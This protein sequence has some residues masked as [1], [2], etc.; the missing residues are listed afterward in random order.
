MDYSDEPVLVPPTRRPIRRWLAIVGTMLLLALVAYVP[1]QK[2]HLDE[3]AHDATRGDRSGAVYP[4]VLDGQT[5]QV[6]LGWVRGPHFAIGVTPTPPAGTT[7]KLNGRFGTEMLTWN[8]E[9]QAFGPGSAIVSPYQ[10]LQLTLTFFDT[11][12][13]RLLKQKRWAFGVVSGHSH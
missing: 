6:E 5:Y 13:R 9:L 1:W 7:L 8:D 2:H 3:L 11:N 10:H 4:A 12:N